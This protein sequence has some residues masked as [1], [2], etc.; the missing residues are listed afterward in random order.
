MKG[1]PEER[2][3][4]EYIMEAGSDGKGGTWKTI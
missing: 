4:E 3:D 1:S 2:D